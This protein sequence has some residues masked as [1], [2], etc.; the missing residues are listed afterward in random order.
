MVKNPLRY[1]FWRIYVPVVWLTLATTIS[2]SFFTLD[3]G[4]LKLML[5]GMP[6]YIVA[7]LVMFNGMVF[8]LEYSAFGKCRRTPLPKEAPLRTIGESFDAF[9]LRGFAGRSNLGIVVFLLYRHG[10]GIKTIYG[11]A[12][13]PLDQIDAIIFDEGID[14]PLVRNSTSAIAHHCPEMK[15]PIYVSRWAAQIMAHYYPTK[16][17]IEEEL[18]QG[19]QY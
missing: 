5:L 19:G 12:F 18:G 9:R 4:Y 2:L 11:T 7:T 1:W 13:V 16:A 14:A 3:L 10:I 15:E 6:F 17:L 8:P